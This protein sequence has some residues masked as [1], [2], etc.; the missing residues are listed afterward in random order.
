[1]SS[2]IEAFLK[3][4]R[5]DEVECL[6]PD[7]AGIARGKILPAKKFLE[8]MRQRGLRIP[9]DVFVQTVNGDYPEDPTPVVSAAARDVYLTPDAETIRIVPWYSEPTAQVICDAFQFSHEPV[10][11]APRRILKKV[12]ELYAEQGWTPTVAPE[13]EFF[14]VD[15]NTDPDYPLEPPI[16]RSGRRETSRQAYGLDAVNEFDPIFEEVYDFC[17]AMNIDIDTLTHEGGAAQM[18][19]NFN[20]GDALLLADQAFL[21]KRAVREAG[22]RHKVYAT[23]MAKP[24]Q[25]EPGSSMHIHQSVLD[26]KTGRNLFATKGGKDTALFRNHIAGLQRYL[27]A[28]MP[29]LAPNVNS[30][31]RL[32]PD[33]DAPINT[34]WGYDNRTVG[35]RVPNSGPENRR[36]ENRL[37][38][39]DANPYLAIATSLACGYLGMMEKLKPRQPVDGSAYRLARTLPRTLYD[40]LERFNGAK[41]LKPVLGAL[42]IQAVTLV[43]YAE[44]DAYQQVISSWERE[45]LLLN[46]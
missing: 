39:A 40:A 44:L 43:K 29:L 33:Y 18:E 3:E 41:A 32:V 38:G 10:E 25:G 8:G 9:E 26:A 1:M 45:H 4:N 20:H 14:L 24:M 42:F 21:F 37:A 36:V 30:Y 35:L 27:P 19:M 46:V 17:E 5:I 11:I 15:V 6:V 23:F 2:A 7:M 12:L 22:L 34:H 16:G 31:R 13:L 28:V